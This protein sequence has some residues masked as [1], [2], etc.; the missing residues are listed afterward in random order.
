MSVVRFSRRRFLQQALVAIGVLAI[1]IPPRR[2][3]NEEPRY[4]TWVLVNSEC[5]HGRVVEEWC[6]MCCDGNSCDTFWCE[7]RDGGPC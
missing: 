2:P 3:A 5:E 6:Y 7:E 4:C 1:E